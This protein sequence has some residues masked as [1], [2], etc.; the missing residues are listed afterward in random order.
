MKTIALLSY[1]ALGGMA[2]LAEV[3]AQP[4][5]RGVGAGAPGVGVLPG[6]GAGAPGVGIAPRPG[7][8][9]RYGA[10]GPASGAGALPGAG[11]GT[12][13]KPVGQ[14]PANVNGG[15]NRAGRR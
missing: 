11:F 14:S 8:E 9:P 5:E 2:A 10:G 4:Y 12:A 15:V 6:A 13:G 1:L 7:V 3:H